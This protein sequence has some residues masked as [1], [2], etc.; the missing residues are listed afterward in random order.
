MKNR[1]TKSDGYAFKMRWKMINDAE[2]R[3]LRDTS[4][5][6][7]FS[8]LAALMSSVEEIGWTKGLR[9]EDK[10]VRERWNKLR[11]YYHV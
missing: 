1:I 7:K 5:I 9:A 11:R 3:E 6:E 8:Q 4:L 10:E 2:R